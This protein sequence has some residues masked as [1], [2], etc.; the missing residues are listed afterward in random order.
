MI[1]TINRVHDLRLILLYYFTLQYN[2][3]KYD[4]LITI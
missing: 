1:I 3:I 4:V 2:V